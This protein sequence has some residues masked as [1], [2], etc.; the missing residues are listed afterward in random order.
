MKEVKELS[1]EEMDIICDEFGK[2]FPDMNNL[3]IIHEKE[4]EEI[5][6]DIGILYSDNEKRN[7]IILFTLGMSNTIMSNNRKCELFVQVPKSYFL[8]NPTCE[9]CCENNKPLKDI[10][11]DNCKIVISDL[12][13]LIKYVAHDPKPYENYN[14]IQTNSGN[15]SI[16]YKM[17]EIKQTVPVDIFLMTYISDDELFNIF[18]LADD[19]EKR[20]EYIGELSREKLI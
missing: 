10:T 11:S 7:Y 19:E 9:I 1:P 3:T 14:T 12:I 6:A 13:S 17:D 18:S 20:Q 2:L 15:K 5:H 4:S 16:L 8:V